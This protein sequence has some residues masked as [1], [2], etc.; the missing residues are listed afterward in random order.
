MSSLWP[1]FGLYLLVILVLGELSARLRVRSLDE[2][3]LSGRRQGTLGTAAT[4]AATVI[5]AGSTLGA[6]GVAYFVG[7]SASWYLLS[8]APGLLLLGL[9]LAPVLRRLSVYTVPEFLEIRYGRRAGLL[10]AALGVVALVLFVSAQFYAMGALVSHLTGLS[11]TAALTLSA[12]AVVAYTWRGG[13][14]A[15]HWSDALQLVWIYAGLLLAAAAAL[16][17]VGG[18]AAFTSPPPAAGFEAMGGTWFHP[19][20]RETTAGWDLFALGNT[21]IAWVVMSTTWHFAMQ[22]TA[23]RVLASRD[24]GVARRACLLAALGIVPLAL[25]VALSGMAARVLYP[26]LGPVAGMEQVN[27]LPALVQ[28][29]LN[30]GVGGIVLAALVAVIMSTCDSALLG[31]GTLLVK[32]LLPRLRVGPGEGAQAIRATR[33]W[34]LGTGALALGVALL[35][36]T[37][38][39]MLEMV[40]AIYCVALFGPLLLGAFWR[41]AT[42]AGALVA[43]VTSGAVGLAWRG[44]RLEAE[45]GVHMLNLSLP[46]SLGALVAVS[47]ARRR[48]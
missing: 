31:A 29:L 45:T 13:N 23:Q 1:V 39:R 16:R 42:E 26:G 3:L 40:A 48:R 20:L 30:P 32:D 8:A 43:M 7:V 24:P 21:V 36:P 38:V 12:V 11:L 44:L 17:L 4:V 19:V 47:L 6:A 27:A 18:L 10:A 41:G 9:T 25:V 33:R 35:A 5:G 2:Y 22:S 34:V 46:L 28:G 15:V 37:L 14:W